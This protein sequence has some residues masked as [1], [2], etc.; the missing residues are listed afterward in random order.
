MAEQE[1]QRWTIDKHGAPRALCP[2]CKRPQA[3]TLAE[4]APPLS[5]C[6]RQT[7]ACRE[8]QKDVLIAALRKALAAAEELRGWQTTAPPSVVEAFDAAMAEVRKGEG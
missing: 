5:Y 3:N 1:E 6:W 4:I 2:S 7:Q 8:H